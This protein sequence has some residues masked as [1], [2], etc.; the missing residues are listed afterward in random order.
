MTLSTTTVKNSYSGNGSTTAFNYS[1]GINSTTELKVIIRSS[2]GTETTKTITTHYTVADAGAAGGTVTFTS[3]NTPASGETGVLLRDTDLTQET[4]YVANDPFPAETHED[5]LDKMQMQIQEIQEEVDRS[6]K[7]SRTNTMTS[8][9]F[10]EN[11]T[12]RASKVFSFDSS[13][14]LSVTN[15]IGNFQGNWAT[16]TAFSLRDI[17]RQNSTSDSSTY[18]NVYI[19]TTAHTSTG[20]YLTQNDT[21]NWAL[22]VEVASFDTLQELNDTDISSLGSGHV[23]IYDGSDSFDNKAISGDA[24]LAANGALTIA[25]SAVETAM[26]ADD[27]VTAAKMAD[28]AVATAAIAADAVTGAKIADDAINSEHYT[29]GSIDTAHIA[30]SNVTTAKIADD[31]ITNA[32][33]ADDAVAAA[34]LAATAITGHTAITSGVDTTNDV[35]LLHDADASANKKISVANLISSAGG[36]TDVVADTSPQL[37]G[38]LDTNS[39]N[40]LIDDAHFIADENSNEQIIFQTTA[41]AVNQFDI[42]NAATGNAPEISATGDDTN[43]SLKLTPKGSG[44]VLLDGNVG[45]E[46]GTIDL[47]NSGSRSKINFYCESGNA[48]AQALQAAPH[49]ESASNTL[50]LPSTGGDVD[51]VSTASTATLTNKSIDSDNN[52]ITNIV[53]ADIKSSAAIADTKLATI[54]TAGKVALSALEIDGGTDIGAAI[55]DDDLFI[56][57]DGAGGTNRKVAASRIKTYAQ[58]TGASKGFAVAMAIAL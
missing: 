10:T 3:G 50:T 55:Q 43:I 21:S 19:C 52:T 18:K 29:D 44:Q 39:H 57:D 30:D 24:T 13:G 9:E 20:S 27:A 53:N 25:N 46:S 23:L 45:I 16:G 28:D 34:E 6:I 35:L 22:L 32:K 15:E 8:T 26:I 47:K 7:L 36:L 38:N 37:G 56:I 48:H 5:A 41:S 58:G 2:L 54:S 40:I 31:A 17:V 49:S 4:D 51:L 11:A 14:E 12:S 42:T 33:L 1:F